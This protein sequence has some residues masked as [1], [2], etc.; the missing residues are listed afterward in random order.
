[1]A[2][3]RPNKRSK[4]VR[5]DDF[6]EIPGDNPSGEPPKSFF[7]SDYNNMHPGSFAKAHFSGGKANSGIQGPSG[8]T[9]ETLVSTLAE[10]HFTTKGKVG[11]D[12]K[13]ELIFC[14]PEPVVAEVK[15]KTVVQTT[16]RPSHKH[17]HKRSRGLLF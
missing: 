14:S 2:Y 5:V 17:R 10:L 11:E 12:G 6:E 16:V 13:F 4:N 3:D 7:F 9:L 15:P 1:M 8:C